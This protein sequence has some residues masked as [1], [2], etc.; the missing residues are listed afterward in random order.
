MNLP[1]TVPWSLLMASLI[2]LPAA[3]VEI[4][5][6]RGSSHDAPENTLASI[7]L[8]WEQANDGV[9]IDIHLTKDGEIVAIH[10]FDTKRT[11][12]R[13]KPVVEQTLAELRELDAGAWKDPK[14]AGER[15][16]TLDEILAT[17][18]EGKRIFIEIKVGPE[19]V[20]TMVESIQRSGK[21]PE[22]LVVI[23]FRY[24]TLRA[25]KEQ[26]PEL[27]HYYLAGY[28]QDRQTGEFPRIDDVIA[29]ALEANFEGINLDYRWPIDREF[30]EKVNGKGLKLY[31]WTVNDPDVAARMRDVGVDGITTDRPLL[32]QEHLGL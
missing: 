11:A 13:D 17:V 4:I 9:E 10:D 31:V 12:G 32:L 14:F 7:Q 29:Q 28:R 25:S 8:G 26:L 18:P 23:A 24:D 19:I 21:K 6:H 27:E 1:T 3:A 20:P 22:Q 30:V 2:V 16:P 15:I 5:A